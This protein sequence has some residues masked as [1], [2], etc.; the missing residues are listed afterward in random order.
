MSFH[1][2][3]LLTQILTP[4]IEIS[5]PCRAKKMRIITSF[6]KSVNA[7]VLPFM[8]T[9]N[10]LILVLN[11]FVTAPQT[12]NAFFIIKVTN[13]DKPYSIGVVY[14]PPNGSEIA[15]LA[16]IDNIMQMNEY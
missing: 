2:L 1:L 5:T 16:E 7:Q 15:A 8:L 12:Q 13:F 14:R 3:E 11:L 6:Q 4:V 10:I 9:I